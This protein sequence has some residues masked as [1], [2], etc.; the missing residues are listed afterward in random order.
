MSEQV[1]NGRYSG[2]NRTF[3]I[4]A[5]LVGLSLVVIGSL[6]LPWPVPLLSLALLVP[7]FLGPRVAWRRGQT[8]R[9]RDIWWVVFVIVVIADMIGGTIGGLPGVVQGQYSFDASL[10][11]VV[12]DGRYLQVGEADGFTYLQSCMTGTAY[13]VPDRLINSVRVDSNADLL[14]NGGSAPNVVAVLRGATSRLG[15]Q[16]CQ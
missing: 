8:R 16:P 3:S 15:L 7:L 1:P 13:A 14:W 9:F 12:P 2:R 5:I 10:L 11:S 4:G 6:L